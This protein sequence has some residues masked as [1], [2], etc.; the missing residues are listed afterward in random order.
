AF[1]WDEDNQEIALYTG[2]LDGLFIV[3]PLWEKS[4]AYM[5][6]VYY[7]DSGSPNFLSGF[8]DF[9]DAVTKSLKEGEIETQDIMEAMGL[10]LGVPVAQ[11]YNIEG[12]VEDIARGKEEV[13]AKRVLGYTENKA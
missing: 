4:V 1:E 10:I 6:G 8:E 5:K 13:G 3:G 9:G 7:H 2:F 12:G 11:L